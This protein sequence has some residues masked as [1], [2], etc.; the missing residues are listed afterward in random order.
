VVTRTPSGPFD[1]LS[2]DVNGDTACDVEDLAVLD[3]VVNGAATLVLDACAAY[4]G[5]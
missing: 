2:C 1:P 5:P 4:G 3:R